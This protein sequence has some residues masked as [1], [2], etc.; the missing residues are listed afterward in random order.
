MYAKLLGL[1]KGPDPCAVSIGAIRLT[2]MSMYG[3]LCGQVLLIFLF[4]IDVVI[5]N[6]PIPVR[7]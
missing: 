5:L 3:R 7:Q 2:G 1:G 4:G 6:G